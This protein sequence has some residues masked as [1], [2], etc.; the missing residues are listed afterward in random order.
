[1]KLTSTDGAA[2]ELR[3]SG[4][5]YPDLTTADELDANW[6]IVHGRVRTAAGEIWTFDDPSL[7]TWEAQ[8]LLDWL[9]AAAEGRLE[10]SDDP[11]SDMVTS[12]L[13][14]IEPNLAFSVAAVEGEQTMLRVH[15]S[16][17]AVAG[18]PDWSAGP[19]PRIYEYSIPF[20]VDRAQ[21]LTAAQQ[22]SS[23]IAPF[24]AR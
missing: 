1:M 8:E 10:P 9:H 5:E 3:L 19:K 23:D 21:L 14:F 2:F 18:K 24:P 22:W 7:T 12:T 11:G 20:R 15:L 16:L 6:V 17:E 13:M 4:Y